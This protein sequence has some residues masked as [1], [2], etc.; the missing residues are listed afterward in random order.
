M[1]YRIG[2][3]VG[4]TFTD[5]LLVKPDGSFVLDKN[6]TTPRDES[7]GVMS[8]IA[9]LA[10]GQSLTLK[11]F[12]GATDV[13][14][15]GTTTADNTMIELS[16]A[17]TGLLVTKG[18]RDEIELR[19]GFK[20]DIWDPSYPAPPQI[21]PRRYR[22][23][24]DERLD[25]EGNVLVPLDEEGARAAVRRLKKAGIESIAIVTL[26]SWV[27]PA[28]EKRIA[29]IVR[30]EYAD[31]EM[32]SVSHEVHAAAP[33]FERTSTTVVNAY[34][35]PRVQKYLKKLSETLRSSGF[36]K[37]LLIMQS[38]GG[39][40]SVDAAIRRPIS[41]LASGPTGGVIGAAAVAK[42]DKVPN[43]ISVDMGG[44]SYDVC[45]V[46]GGEPNVKSS[47][48]WVNR[49][50]IALP[51][52][53]VISIGAGGGSI[54]RVR[55]GGLTVGPESAGS[56]PGPI[57]YGR[58]GTEPTVTDA[59]LVL[60]YLNPEYF[61]GGTF[62]LKQD[63]VEEIL[64]EKIGE[65]LGFDAVQAA[66]GIYRL[67]N[68][69]MNNAI[70]RV[71][72][73]RGL[74]PREFSLVVFGGNGA[75]HALAQADD[76]GITKVLIPKTAPAFSALGL[77]VADNL[78]DKVRASLVASSEADPAKLEKLYRQLEKDAEAE[79]R[80]AGVPAKRFSH[81]RF[82]QCRYP[83]QTWDIDVP[84]PGGVLTKASIGTIAELF[85]E[86]HEHEHTYARR[87]EDVLISGVRVRSRG[88]VDKPHMPALR[89]GGG[90][91]KPKGSRKAYFGDGF[92]KTAVYDGERIRAGQSVKGPAI[93]EEP[94]TTIVVP[95]GWS[96]KL[97][98]RGNY[99]A[100]H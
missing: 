84:I 72:A 43:F 77:L 7:A 66:W 74:D 62:P 69:D 73:E 2:I 41:T 9:R 83:G 11:E 67:V 68:A 82:A 65:P 37:G 26:F 70:T 98:K 40:T 19:R 97:D 23:T 63:T 22:L 87:E 33:E 29:E 90:A 81:Q 64:E 71:S 58:G 48:N 1:G 92:R 89:G 14:I 4:G 94:F 5:F 3:D 93:V 38:S 56:D 91:P 49:Y 51:M 61:A 31:V 28:H 27:N 100:T 86:M 30:E 10:D 47:W 76:L 34:V 21:V 8:G 12:L 25:Y 6:F 18:A 95:P 42:E 16:G 15:H 99:V 20:E 75:V 79:L 52:V 46:R 85:H 13:I 55:A 24:V 57:C 39:I 17:K 50:L 59:N 53:D 80:Q 35:G 45:L 54:A 96:V 78:V 36:R 88:V 32:L 44:T 60:G